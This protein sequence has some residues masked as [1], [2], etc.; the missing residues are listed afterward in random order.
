MGLLMIRKGLFDKALPYLRKALD[1]QRKRNLNPY[2]GE[3]AYYLGIAL[4][5]LRKYEEAYAWLY[6]STWNGSWQDAGFFSCAQI[7][8][9]EGRLEEALHEV[10]RSLLRNMTN[11]KARAL[12]ANILRK[13][14]RPD[15][16]RSCISD[17]ICDDLFNFGA[18]FELFLITGE[19]VV[20]ERLITLMRHDSHNY[21][22]V[23]LDYI[24]AGC[25]EEALALLEIPEQL[26]FASPMVGYYKGYALFCLGNL[27][28][29]V[30]EYR[31]A[32]AA[33]PLLCFPNSIHAVNP[34]L[35]AMTLNPEDALAPYYL[36]NLYYDKK[37]DEIAIELWQK[38]F[39]L[40]P[41]YP[42]VCRNLALGYYN[43]RHDRQRALELMERAF[44]LDDT[45]ARILMELD[46]LRKQ[47][48]VDPEERLRIL[49]SYPTLTESRDDLVVEKAT[50]LNLCGRYGE[51]IDLL[52]S[53]KFHPW[54]GGEGKVVAQYQTARVELAKIALASKRYEDAIKLLKECLEYPEYPG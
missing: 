12:K 29:A 41:D 32:S 4:K 1:R 36:G 53:R 38:S 5:F 54:E 22:E 11:M 50:L 48:A 17:A 10:E 16:A 24:A 44:A 3:P 49:E 34:L 2:D 46:Q 31:K 15:D 33:S 35:T 39:E 6:K 23:A 7:S 51:A 37:C 26:G 9:I 47:L 42:T 20:R 28:E 13:L 52:A 25:Y 40:N 19:E 14:G 8:L 30:E 21:E 43:K 45:D 18:W 27:P